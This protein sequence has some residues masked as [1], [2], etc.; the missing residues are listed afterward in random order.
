VRMLE[1]AEASIRSMRTHVFCARYPT[2]NDPTCLLVFLQ[3]GLEMWND[4]V[5][6]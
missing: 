1:I 5:R 4:F 3:F 2:S 6:F